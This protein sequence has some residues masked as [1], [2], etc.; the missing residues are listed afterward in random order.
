MYMAECNVCY[1]DCSYG[2]NCFAKCSYVICH[3]CFLNLLN[4][5]IV[6]CVEYSCPQCRNKSVKNNDK[7]FTRFI[8][9]NKKCLKKIVQ[10]YE[11]KLEQTNTR[12]LSSAWNEFN[13][14]TNETPMTYPIIYFDYDNLIF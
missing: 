9:N 7:R 5:N 2:V 6:D 4:L 13:I 10:L 12:T 11:S 8:N 3:D 1:N 14:Q